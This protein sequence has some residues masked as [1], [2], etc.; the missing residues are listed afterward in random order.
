MPWSMKIH[1]KFSCLNQAM[2]HACTD[3]HSSSETATGKSRPTTKW[4]RLRVQT[5]SGGTWVELN[6]QI[7]EAGGKTRMA[8]AGP[9]NPT[10]DAAS[11]K[12]R[13]PSVAATKDLFSPFYL[14]L[15]ISGDVF[16][17]LFL[18]RRKKKSV[19]MRQEAGASHLFKLT[20]WKA[21]NGRRV[22]KQRN[23]G[24]SSKLG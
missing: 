18:R 23:L 3:F 11:N 12:I 5:L 19:P 17:K 13:V 20:V 22:R 4:A 8:Q 14:R 15:N 9:C 16:I 1:F 10:Y 2:P 7:D 21:G 6:C 24:Y